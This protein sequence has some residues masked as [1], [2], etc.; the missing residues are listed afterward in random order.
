LGEKRGRVGG[1]RRPKSKH[2]RE[3]TRRNAS[4]EDRTLSR[5]SSKRGQQIAQRLAALIRMAAM[6]V[7][8]LAQLV[9]VLDGMLQ[10]RL[11][12]S[13]QR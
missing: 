13:D 4:K 6:Q 12:G 1:S 7:D 10:R 5:A 3:V 2:R 8:E 11:P 9:D